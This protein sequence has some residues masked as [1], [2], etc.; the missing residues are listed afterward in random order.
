MLEP[1]EPV[2][3]AFAGAG[4]W[5]IR[6][7]VTIFVRGNYSRVVGKGRIIARPVARMY[8]A[9]P[10]LSRAAGQVVVISAMATTAAKW[11][12]KIRCR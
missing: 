8:I 2:T 5:A 12:C 9:L 6:K 3:L 7:L 10:F 1:Q 4:L 11:I